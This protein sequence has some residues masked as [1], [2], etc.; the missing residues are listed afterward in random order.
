MDQYVQPC[1]GRL[2]STQAWNDSERLAQGTGA[3]TT[4]AGELGAGLPHSD[5][6]IHRQACVVWV[7]R[8]GGWALGAGEHMRSRLT[9]H[10]K[11]AV[12]G[13]DCPVPSTH[14]PPA[15]TSMPFSLSSVWA[16]MLSQ[17]LRSCARQSASAHER[18]AAQVVEA[19]SH[20]HPP[21]LTHAPSLV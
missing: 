10:R 16:V 19:E 17:P 8:E 4:G 7:S 1:S 21:A 3:G 6:S 15:P 12:F 9:T 20:W 5:F 13:Q 11:A 14:Q 18:D 2:S